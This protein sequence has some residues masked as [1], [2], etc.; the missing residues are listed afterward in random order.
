MSVSGVRLGRPGAIA[1]RRS[2]RILEHDLL[3]FRRGWSSYLI[4]GLS[5]ST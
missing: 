5:G 2:L 1:S 3:V 4:S